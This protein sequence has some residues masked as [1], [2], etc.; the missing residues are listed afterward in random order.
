MGNTPRN[1]KTFACIFS[2][3]TLL[4]ILN[5]SFSAVQGILLNK[6]SCLADIND[7]T[8]SPEQMMQVVT[9]TQCAVMCVSE[10]VAI[11]VVTQGHGGLGCVLLHKGQSVPTTGTVY[12]D[13]PSVSVIIYASLNVTSVSSATSDASTTSTTTVSSETSS[14]Q[15]ANTPN[16]TVRSTT[17]CLQ[18]LDDIENSQSAAT[19]RCAAVGGALPEVETESHMEVGDLLETGISLVILQCKNKI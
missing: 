19:A 16:I 10:C 12:C 1:C 5:V 2:T 4:T 6:H 7:L 18:L 11:A 14:L 15:S 8:S 13:S 17:Y 3:A 9:T